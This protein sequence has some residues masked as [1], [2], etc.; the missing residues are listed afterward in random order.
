M[1]ARVLESELTMIPCG[2]EEY[3]AAL[4]S[5]FFPL[6]LELASDQIQFQSGLASRSIGGMR[7]AR[8][9]A[10]TSF[11][12]RR[13]GSRSP[14]GPQELLLHLTEEG[15]ILF[16]Q[17]GQTALCEPGALIL[18]DTSQDLRTEQCCAARSLAVALPMPLLGEQVGLIRS[19][20]MV[21][22]ND[23]YGVTAILRDYLQSLWRETLRLSAADGD[24]LLAACA[25]LA[26]L[27]FARESDGTYEASIVAHQHMRRIKQIIDDNLANPN[28]TAAV[29]S[30]QAG[31]SKSYLYALMKNF[32]QTLGDMVIERRLHRCKADL[33]DPA[34]H[35]R[36]ITDIAFS[37]GFQDLSHFS[38]RFK[39][40]FGAS[41]SQLRRTSLLSVAPNLGSGREDHLAV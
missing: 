39:A 30:E 3:Q 21:V 32:S 34:L 18:I 36:T 23:E 16:R 27:A 26:V 41:P 38:R 11:R 20:G 15:R 19:H 5:S 1:Q 35:N 14:G 29:I 22:L 4:S 8:A 10:N 9:Y 7:L 6:E 40:M 37:W 33:C 2:I 25:R 28:L 12:T 17:N 31:I 24:A 13:A